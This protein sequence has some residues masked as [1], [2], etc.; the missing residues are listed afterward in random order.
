MTDDSEPGRHSAGDGEGW[1][2][3]LRVVLLLV[4]LVVLFVIVVDLL[5]FAGAF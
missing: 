2:W 4:V 3:Y 5:T 1:P